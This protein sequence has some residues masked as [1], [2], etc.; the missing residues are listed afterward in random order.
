[1]QNSA[2]HMR[3]ERTMLRA[4]LRTEDSDWRDAEIKL[5]QVIGNNDGWFQW[6]GSDLSES[7]RELRLSIEGGACLPILRAELRDE[8]GNWNTRNLNLGE[9]LINRNGHFELR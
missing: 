7:T 4:R 3:V 5:N 8:H 1:F 6:G 2:M 9:R